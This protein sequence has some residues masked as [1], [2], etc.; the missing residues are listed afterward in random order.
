MAGGK[1]ARAKRKRV[2]LVLGAGGT[3]GAAW[4]IGGL[5]AVEERIGRPLAEVDV[6]VGTSAGS[7]V[8]AALRHGFTPAE[9]VAHQLGVGSEHLPGAQEFESDSG[10]LPSAPRLRLRSARQDGRTGRSVCRL[11]IGA[12]T[13]TSSS[14]WS[15][16]RSREAAERTPPST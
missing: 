3:L 7:I 10:R 11:A 5:A 2:G 16:S 9:L 13:N 4:T 8:A 6:I 1:R 14:P 12:S 15:C